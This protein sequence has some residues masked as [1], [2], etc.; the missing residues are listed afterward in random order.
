MKYDLLHLCYTRQIKE[1][2]KLIERPDQKKKIF[3]K[4]EILD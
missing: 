3:I 4:E 1:K 2:I